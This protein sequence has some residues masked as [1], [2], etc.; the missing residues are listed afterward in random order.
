MQ[1]AAPWH[2]PTRAKTEMYH[3]LF[4]GKDGEDPPDIDSIHVI[5]QSSSG[6]VYAPHLYAPNEIES[7]EQ[8]FEWF[9]GGNYT[10]RARK[11]GRICAETRFA[12]DGPSRPLVPPSSGAPAA[13]AAPVAMAAPAHSSTDALLL[14]LLQMFQATT[15]QNAAAMLEASRANTQ[16]MMAMMQRSDSQQ[17]AIVTTLTEASTRAQQSQAEFY[18]HLAELGKSS[19]GG[20]IDA[21][22]E[23]MNLGTTVSEIIKQQGPSE[24]DGLAGTIGTLVQSFAAAQQAPPGVPP[25]GAVASPGFLPAAGGPNA[26]THH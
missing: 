5:R 17:T 26:P 22:K 19:S 14:G 15:Q 20:S 8:V 4:P 1:T 12:L 3:P 23:G 24:D 10:L 13:P 11:N 9:G 25:A 18:K 7:L 2:P 6:P 21:F 16:L